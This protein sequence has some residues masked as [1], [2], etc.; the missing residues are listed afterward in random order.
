MRTLYKV[1]NSQKSTVPMHDLR[2]WNSRMICHGCGQPGHKARNCTI[3]NIQ[4]TKCMLC[5]HMESVCMEN[6]R[7]APSILYIHCGEDHPSTSCLQKV[8]GPTSVNGCGNVMPTLQSTVP[9]T[10]SQPRMGTSLHSC[11]YNAKQ[12]NQCWLGLDPMFSSTRH[13][14]LP[15]FNVQPPY[16]Q[17]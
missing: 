13:Q 8:A 16:E 11:W 3:K 6:S 9:L 10:P 1:A 7:P 4:C 14:D 5:R 12:V 17:R 15:N 2:S